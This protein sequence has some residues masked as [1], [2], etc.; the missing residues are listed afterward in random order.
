MFA[1]ARATRRPVIV[2]DVLTDPALT[3]ADCADA[4]TRG[5]RAC[6]SVPLL[7]GGDLIGF[8]DLHNRE[9]RPFT[10][11]DAIVGLAQIAGQAVVNARL[12]RELDD[13]VRWMT[14]MSESALELSSSLDLRDTLLAT[15]KRLC[16]SVGVPE[17]EITVIEDEGLRTLMRIEHGR[18]DEAWIGQYL[19]LADAAVT[20]EVITTKRPT[21]VRSLR[22]PRLTARVHE[23]NKDYAKKSWATLPLIVQDRVI[24]TVE[25][26]ESGE[27]RTFTEGELKTA[28]AVCHAAAMAIENATLFES[29]RPPT[30]RHSCSTRSRGGRRRASISKRSSAPP[31]MNCASSCRSTATPCS[32]PRAIT[33]SA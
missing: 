22:D 11:V 1:E 32:S 21:V 7:A 24:G 23:I 6:M 3:P 12:Y 25:L 19:S 16:E 9:S 8:I 10:A 17:C 28:T 13:S 30:R 18:V 2:L 27:E 15:A 5:Y 29:Q 14:L 31:S 26:V 33:S 20:R 4:E